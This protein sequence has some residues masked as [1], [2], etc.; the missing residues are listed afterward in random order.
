MILRQSVVAIVD[1]DPRL[2]ES[3]GDLLESVGHAVRTFSSP[4]AFLAGD[5][6]SEIDC[7]VTDITM[8]ELD[9]FDLQ[10]MANEKRP[11]LPVI[12]ITGTHDIATEQ[13]V[14]DLPRGRFFR[15]PFNSQELVSAIAGALMA[16]GPST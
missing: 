10:Q 14:M 5:L 16:K 1:D 7:L 3:L 2:L 6:L 4:H 9:G 12:F 8:P 11:D 13:R 15:K